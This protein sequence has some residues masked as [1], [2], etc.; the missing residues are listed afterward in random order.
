MDRWITDWQ[1]SPRLP[2]YTRANAG[3]VLPEPCSPLAWTLTWEP[4]MCQGFRDAHLNSLGTFDEH[5]LDAEHPETF[6]HFGGYLYINASAV[7]VFGHR[8]PGLSPEVVDRMYFGDHPEVPPFVP[9]PWH[10]RAEATE[11]MGLWLAHVLSVDDLPELRADRAEADAVRAGRPDLGSLTDG[12]L[13]ERARSFAPMLR[14][15]FERHITVTGAASIGPGVL[16]AIGVAV[17]DPTMWLSLI[18]AVGDVDSAAP[19]QALWEL[20]RAVRRSSELRAAFDAG[21][22]GLLTRL[23]ASDSQATH[24]FLG[25]LDR[26]L[27]LYGSRGPNEWDIRSDTWETDPELVVALIDRLRLAPDED[28]P[29]RRAL[30]R[31]RE[32]KE[33]ASRL[34]EA[35]ATDPE[36]QGQLLAGLRS[37]ALYLAGRERT[38]TNIIKVLHEVRM[39][40]R[41]L[42]AR[43]GYTPDEIT[44]LLADELDAFVADPSAFRARLGSR[45]QQY[46]SLFALEPPFLVNGVVPPLSAWPRRT[47][48]AEPAVPGEVLRGVGGCPGTATGRAR[49]VLDPGDPHDLEPGDVLVAPITDP[50]WTPLFVSAAAVIVDV[51]AAASHAVIVS[52]ELGIPCVVSVTDATKRIADGI[53]V[54]VDGGAGL[55]TVH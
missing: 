29:A 34:T 45:L 14:R 1:P 47:R 6:G 22:D 49:V 26:F 42:G 30:A 55:V 51:G 16:Q 27:V 48:T 37:S 54:T 41:E 36:A 20:S 15:L 33:L 31:A 13:V 9:E 25:E 11:K 52:R 2:L 23:R 10:D 21:L 38:K 7:R 40:I 43:H 18:T 17:G 4:G 19:S 5:E 53:I 32:R 28:D 3:E 12:E 44:M 24:P 8:G 39:T 35:L 50:A 46:R